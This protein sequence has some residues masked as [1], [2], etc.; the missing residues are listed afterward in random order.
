MSPASYLHLGSQEDSFLFSGLHSI[1]RA[2]PARAL[3]NS[4]Y[5]VP[6]LVTPSMWEEAL[7]WQ[8]MRERQQCLVGA[9]FKNSSDYLL[10][11]VS[12]AQES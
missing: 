10:G 4:F 8:R 3:E 12:H 9:D 1:H 2:V 7:Y 5:H 6:F 11:E